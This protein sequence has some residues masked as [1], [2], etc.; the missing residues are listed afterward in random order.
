M[1]NSGSG[2]EAVGAI[3]VDDVFASGIG[4]LAGNAE[5]EEITE[6]SCVENSC[7]VTG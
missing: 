1:R 6:A 4:S 5:V 2:T 3:H 7:S